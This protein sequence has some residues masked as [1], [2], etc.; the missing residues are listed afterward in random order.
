MHGFHYK[1]SVDKSLVDAACI[2]DVGTNGFKTVK[3]AVGDFF[4]WPKNQVVVDPKHISSYSW[5][6]PLTS[7]L[8]AYI[9]LSAL[10][11]DIKEKDKIKA[12][13]DKIKQEMESLEKSI[14]SKSNQSKPGT[15]LERARKPKAEGDSP[16]VTPLIDHHCCYKYGDS[17]DGFFCNQ[18]TC[19]FC[20][21]DA[22]D[23]Y[24]CPSYVPFIQTLPSF[25]QQY[26]CCEDCGGPHETFRSIAITLDLPTVEPKDSL[27]MGDEHLDTI[28]ETKSN[29]FIKSSVKN[30][31][32][33]PKS[34]LNHDSS[35]ISSSLKINSLL[36]EFSGELILLKSIPLGIDETDCD[37]E[38]EIR[39]IEI[40]FY[41]NSSPRPPEEFI[42]E[43]SDAKIESFSPSP[44]P[45]E[46]S[47]SLM[48]E[49]N[50]TH[51]PDDSLP[52][53]IEEDDYDSERD[54]LIL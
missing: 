46:D 20:G 48:K 11:T 14:K 2:P 15:D 8:A 27:R 45:V 35:I 9:C 39:L 25:P 31:V 26:P 36:D 13:T 29:E 28:L 37:P 32:P 19:E 12:K 6:L 1:V 44:I 40:L 23:G 38:E 10:E 49:I 51:I 18:C 21:N 50:L 34:L 33:N 24:N 47:D 30:F 43:N 52:P 5:L 53:G 7:T 16:G 41:D 3:D 17:L 54:M 4:A 42:F 22:H